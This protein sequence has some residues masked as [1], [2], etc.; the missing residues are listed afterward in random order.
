MA[1]L[2][3]IDFILIS[4]FQKH[5]TW[6]SCILKL[7]A[8]TCINVFYVVLGKNLTSD[9]S[10]WTQR[11]HIRKSVAVLRCFE[12]LR[13]PI[14]LT[15]HSAAEHDDTV[16]RRGA[17]KSCLGSR[18]EPQQQG[19]WDITY[20]SRMLSIIMTWNQTLSYAGRRGF[21]I[22]CAGTAVLIRVRRHQRL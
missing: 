17:T 4:Q 20:S 18:D 6:W 12:Q 7:K 19:P 10:K 5:N 15:M 21:C 11:W 8:E 2:P 22:L 13:L 1:S 14:R 16:I 9:S 3:T